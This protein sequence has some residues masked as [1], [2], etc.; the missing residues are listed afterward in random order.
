MS[1]QNIFSMSLLPI[2]FSK[3]ICFRPFFKVGDGEGGGG[4]EGGMF[5]IIVYVVKPVL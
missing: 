5:H 2:Y 4:R 3:P 1:I